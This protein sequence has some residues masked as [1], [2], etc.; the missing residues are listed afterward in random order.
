[1]GAIVTYSV[2]LM[3]FVIATGFI[4][5]PKRSRALAFQ[6]T[7]KEKILRAVKTVCLVLAVINVILLI[8]SIKKFI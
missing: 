8:N 3:V 5:V 4:Q 7:K 6:E 2:L 1:M